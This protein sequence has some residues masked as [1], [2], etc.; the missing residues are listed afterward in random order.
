MLEAC[1]VRYWLE[2]GSLLGAIRGGDILPWDYDVDLGIYREDVHRVDWLAK[3]KSKPIADD[4]GFVWEKASEGDF[5]RVH[6]SHV[7]RLHV[8]IFPFY[9]KNGTMTKNSW[10]KT[11]RQ[12]MEFPEHFLKPLSSIDF[13]GRTVSAPNNIH[14]FLELK[15]GEGVVEN[16]SYPNPLKMESLGYKTAPDQS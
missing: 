15:F 14:D 10:F 11:H 6:F 16:P 9:S 4:L 8:D 1:G 3:A 5:F 7:N 13:V 2:G 12:D